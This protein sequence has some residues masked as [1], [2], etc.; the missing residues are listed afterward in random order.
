MRWLLL[1]LLMLAGA[2]AF[3][4]APPADEL[5]QKQ[6]IMLHSEAQYFAALA[7]RQKGELDKLKAAPCP[8]EAKP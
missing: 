3:A 5:I 8:G 7:E 1:L 2:A 4:Q 6:I